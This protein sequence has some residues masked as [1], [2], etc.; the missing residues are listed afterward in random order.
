[1]VS[2]RLCPFGGSHASAENP[3]SQNYY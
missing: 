3:Q 2:H 1:V